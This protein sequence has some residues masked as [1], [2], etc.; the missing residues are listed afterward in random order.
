MGGPLGHPV[1][2]RY[3]MKGQMMKTKNP[4]VIQMTDDSVI[5]SYYARERPTAK[6]LEDVIDIYARAGVNALS[7]CIHCRFQA[8]YDSKVVEVA[9]DLTP[10]GV[11]PWRHVH[12]WHWL[13]AL[14]RLIADGNDPPK[15]LAARC[16][17]HGMRFLPCFRLNDQ[18]GFEPNQAIYGSFRRDHPEWRIDKR[19]MDYGVSDV[20][21]HVL[22]VAR[23]VC[24]GYDIDGLDLDFQRWPVFFKS[25]EV[26]ANTPLMTAFVKE[27]RAYLDEAGKRLN[28]SMLLSVRVPIKIGRGQVIN[29]PVRHRDLECLGVG[30]DVPTWIKEGLVNIVCPMAF[31]ANQWPDMIAHMAQWRELTQDT[32]C[33]LHPTIH[34]NLAWPVKPYDSPYV[35]RAS[36]RGAAHSYYRHGADGIAL[37]NLWDNDKVSWETVPDLGNPS[38]LG[39][40]PRRYHVYLDDPVLIN[41]GE[42]KTFEL[43]LPEDP[44]DADQRPHLRFYAANLTLEHRIEIDI[45]GTK[46]DPGTLTLDRIKSGGLS[47]APKMPYGY[48]V[49][50][51]LAHTSTRTGSNELGI[52]VIEINPELSQLT[53]VYTV[54]ESAGGIAVGLIETLFGYPAGLP[55]APVHANLDPLD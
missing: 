17:Q 34:R 7:H 23:E 21:E 10:E 48:L 36:Y 55:A 51:P 19:A 11:E 3:A 37:Y 38:A 9:G 41:K 53:K 43:F 26:K 20:R 6:D 13:T 47:G 5:Y 40:K 32:D 52:K 25:D 54:P 44:Q 27:I 31:L 46:V 14:R 18:H 29:A 35:S 45:N 49:S 50:F 12:Y 24:Q 8:Y 33:S 30:L 28:R 2:C 42:R 39:A 4:Q 16:H 1:I 22:T 15:V